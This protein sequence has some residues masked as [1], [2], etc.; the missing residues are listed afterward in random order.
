[1]VIFIRPNFIVSYEN[2]GGYA[3]TAMCFAFEI[4]LLCGF[5]AALLCAGVSVE[6]VRNLVNARN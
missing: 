5:I 2:T 3:A 1:M 6:I 4:V